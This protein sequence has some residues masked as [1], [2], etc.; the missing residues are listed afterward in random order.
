LDLR[1]ADEVEAALA[2]MRREVAR[3]A[4]A[5]NDVAESFIVERMLEAPL[6]EL[7]INIRADDQ[8]GMALTLASGGVL[9]E[10]VADAITLLLPTDAV[11]IRAALARLKIAPLLDGFRGRAA[12]DSDH[13][14]RIIVRLADYAIAERDSIA[15][16][17][18]NPL[19]VYADDAV[20]VDALVQEWA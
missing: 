15:E 9:V 17:E 12:A 19:L 4:P 13:L 5:M 3:A 16:I 14:A 8:F 6:A 11:E 7:L 20:A 1:C 2:R 18:I 10:V